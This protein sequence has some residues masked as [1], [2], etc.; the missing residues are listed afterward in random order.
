MQEGFLFFLA[1]DSYWEA[2]IEHRV[3][4]VLSDDL[5]GLDGEG[6]KEGLTGRGF[7]YTYG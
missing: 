7:M 2:A 4:S 6:W 5:D 1:L 3:S